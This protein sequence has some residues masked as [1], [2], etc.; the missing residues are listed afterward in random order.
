MSVI[1]QMLRD[2]EK[3]GAELVPE[4]L[5]AARPVNAASRRASHQ[6]KV[7]LGLMIGLFLLAGLLWW[8]RGPGL[9]PALLLSWPPAP[10]VVQPGNTPQVVSVPQQRQQQPQQQQQPDVQPI[11]APVTAEP[12]L[13]VA[14]AV[15]VADAAGVAAVAESTEAAGQEAVPETP[16]V[17]SLAATP[18]ASEPDDP[19]ANPDPEPL[20][21]SGVDSATEAAAPPA[22]VA[23]EI[24]R[25]ELQMDRSGTGTERANR[26]YQDARRH[27]QSGDWRAA[28]GAL[29]AAVSQDPELL[30]A[31][32][33]LITLLQRQ[34]RQGDART[35]LT[36]LVAR[37]PDNSDLARRYA[38]LLVDAG[39]WPRAA[40][41]LAQAEANARQ[42][43]AFLTLQGNVER[44]LGRHERS[45]QAYQDAL[46]LAPQDARLW[47]GLG[48][49]LAG[50]SQYPAAQA[51][52]QRALDS[53]MLGGELER[54][55]QQQIRSLEGRSRS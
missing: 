29:E 49:A 17:T 45:V 41:V 31:Q 9:E 25:A 51:A 15:G 19:A 35:R 52:Y 36:E 10:A 16:P 43:L 23:A 55:L 3:R 47:L 14:G 40:E 32:L 5:A 7:L 42:D 26:S 37:H 4:G 50:N 22:A 38:R 8:Q 33:A 46:R 30:D 28:Q 21:G 53:G 2:L 6:Q 11:A 1:N 18:S 12:V 54:W 24:P 48:I 34:G 20:T 39:D 13:D 44:R 27:L